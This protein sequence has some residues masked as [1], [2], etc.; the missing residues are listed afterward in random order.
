MTTKIE[1]SKNL[2]DTAK[3]VLRWKFLAI[4]SYEI[5]KKLKQPNITPKETREERKD[6]D[7]N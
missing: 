6:K 7:Q 4:Q 5:R 1:Q 2:W 3:A